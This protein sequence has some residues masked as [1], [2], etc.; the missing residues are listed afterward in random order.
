[1]MISLLFG[2]CSENNNNQNEGVMVQVYVPD[3]TLLTK[4]MNMDRPVDTYQ[5]PITPNSEGW[6]MLPSGDA[7][8]KALQ[9][10]QNILA[11]MST[12][13]I[14]QSICEYPMLFNIFHRAEYQAD[15]VDVLENNASQELLLH[16]DAGRCLLKR[17][18]LL[19]IDKMDHIYDLVYPR[20]LEL[21]IMQP[22][23]LEQLNG[24]DKIQLINLVLEKEKIIENAST[25]TLT[26]SEITWILVAKVLMAANY[27]PFVQA[28]KADKSLQIFVEGIPFVTYMGEYGTESMSPRILLYVQE[29]I[30]INKGI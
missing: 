6:T 16:K 14:I 20:L 4:S 26:Y 5:Y 1:M 10:P 28:V 15:F 8:I 21:L 29:F 11:S 30:K 22:A 7:M 2:S 13:T 9:I 19:N 24:E 25:L 12:Q 27:T 3:L 17:I 23:I 18:E